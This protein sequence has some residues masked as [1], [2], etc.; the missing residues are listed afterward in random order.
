MSKNLLFFLSI[1]KLNYWDEEAWVI[2]TQ[3]FTF[4]EMFYYQKKGSSVVLGKY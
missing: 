3:K 1:E 4:S 2:Q